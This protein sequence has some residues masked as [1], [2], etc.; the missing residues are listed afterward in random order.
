MKALTDTPTYNPTYNPTYPT[1]TLRASGQERLQKGY[2][3]AVKSLPCA[4]LS[5]IGLV[6]IWLIH[7]S[8]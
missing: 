5:A 2:N 3:Q 8:L 1:Y 6:V 7:S 4:A